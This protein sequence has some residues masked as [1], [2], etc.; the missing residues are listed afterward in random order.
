MPDREALPIVVDIEGDE[1]SGGSRPS[2]RRSLLIEATRSSISSSSSLWLALSSASD[3]VVI[4]ACPA[5]PQA[6]RR[7][8]ERMLS[9]AA[10]GCLQ[11]AA[12]LDGY[13][14]ATSDAA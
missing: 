2:A 14:I 11:P 7:G 5:G 1:R 3:A 6:A 12:A 8:R 13:A 9:S 10:G 4:G